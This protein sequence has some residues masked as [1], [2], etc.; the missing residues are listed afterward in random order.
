MRSA[1]WRILG[2]A[3]SD[4]TS[5]PASGKPAPKKNPWTGLRKHGLR[6]QP[7]LG[8]FGSGPGH[9]KVRFEPPAQLNN[10]TMHVYRDIAIGRYTFLR[11]GRFRYL[12]TIGRYT[13]IGPDVTIGEGEHP[14]SW[15][16]TSPAVHHASR[17]HYYPPEADSGPRTIK[18]HAGNIDPKTM[19][20]ANI[21]NDVWIGANV[22]IRRGVTIGDGAIVA[23]GAFVNKDVAPYTI[24]GGLPAKVIGKRFSDEIIDKLLELKW[25]EFDVS[26]LSGIPFDDVEQAIEQIIERERA[27]QISRVPVTYDEVV[28]SKKGY[29][30]LTIDPLNAQ[31]A[32]DRMKRLKQAD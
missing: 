25:W 28:I 1:S 27:G 14:V 7:G 11:S 22:L 17:F 13:S 20:N 32:A 30:S 31:R 2:E 8:F 9:I 26:D 4:T 3:P 24:V 29:R 10:A 5:A 16:T 23:A 12:D 6:V 15:L 21:G 19:A 18:R